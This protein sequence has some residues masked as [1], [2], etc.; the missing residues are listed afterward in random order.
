MAERISQAHQQGQCLGRRCGHALS[1]PSARPGRLIFIAADQITDPGP[2]MSAMTWSLLAPLA[3]GD[4]AELL[5]SARTRHYERDEE[6]FHEGDPGDSLHLVNKGRL[7]VRVSTPDG[8]SATLN[9]LGPGDYFGELALLRDRPVQERT[10]S[11]VAL[12]PVTTL[13][14]SGIA[15]QAICERHPAVERLVATLLAD[16]IEQLS[17][18]LLE[19]LYVGVD[20]RVWR[21]LSELA[22]MYADDNRAP[23]VVIPLTQ[24]HLADLAGATR[25]TVNQVLQH[26]AAEGL[27]SLGRGRMTVRD[28]DALRHRALS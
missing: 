20:R 1:V 25:P 3:A 21:R 16:R 6:V 18:R 15:F 28:R 17:Q 9:V 8:E 27:V 24:S 5:A 11:V 4:R 26:L 7:S 13:S 14:V 19:A 12:E 22:D 2:T 10:A 23:G